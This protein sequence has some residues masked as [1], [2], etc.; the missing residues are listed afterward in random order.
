MSFE[1]E[2]LEIIKEVFFLLLLACLRQ[3]Q[4]SLACLKNN[5]GILLAADFFPIV[6]RCDFFSARLTSK[7]LRIVYWMSFYSSFVS[8]PLCIFL[9]E[10]FILCK[11]GSSSRVNSDLFGLIK[12]TTDEEEGRGY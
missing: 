1:N 10:D 2:R 7:C 3:E 9:F 5:V 6:A 8:S 4:Q 12:T 11:E